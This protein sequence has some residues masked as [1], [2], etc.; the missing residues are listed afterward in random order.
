MRCLVTGGAGF[1]G[2]H[3]VLALLESGHDVLVIDNFST[4]S[5]DVLKRVTELAG[6][7]VHVAERDMRDADALRNTFARWSPDAVLHFAGLKSVSESVE[8][9]VHYYDV[10]LAGTV[11]LLKAM[12]S[13][14]CHRLVFSSSAT[15]YGK[16]LYLPF[17]EAHPTNPVTPYARSKLAV[18]N[19]LHDWTVAN[20]ARAVTALRYF[21]PVGAHPSGRLGENPTSVPHNLM[22]Y[23]S[24]TALGRRAF[25][26]V[27]GDDYDARDG[28][29][30]RDYIHVM[31]LAEAHLAALGDLELSVGF[32][33][34]N[35]GTGQGVT[36]PEM[37]TAFEAAS[38]VTIPLQDMPRR[39]GDL[40]GFYANPD[41]AKNNLGWKAKRGIDAMCRDAWA[42]QV[43]SPDGLVH[44]EDAR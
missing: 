19:L 25:L 4:S 24:Q 18:E 33:I 27:L 7:I 2:S 26:P 5:P 15:V 28:T 17:D 12:D 42:W 37:V 20:S 6:R 31:D 32:Q 16:P 10:N 8:D 38:G 44:T 9:P 35:V 41:R 3:T 14:A 36:V 29:G 11:N 30:E 34:Y 1:I 22:Q 39:D 21:N 43:A 40:P 13:V 23:M